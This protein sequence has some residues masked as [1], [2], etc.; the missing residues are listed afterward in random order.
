MGGA[1]GKVIIFDPTLMDKG[2]VI[3]C[4]TKKYS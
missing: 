2:S 1:K 3:H 4:N